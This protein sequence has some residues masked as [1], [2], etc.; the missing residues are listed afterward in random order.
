MR[1]VIVSGVS[2]GIGYAVAKKLI[3]QGFFVVGV[4]RSKHEICE[5]L[6]N[7]HKNSMSEYICDIS[8]ISRI[9]ELISEIVKVEDLSIVRDLTRWLP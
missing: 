8:E 5:K 1:K 9:P 2:G 3:S 7:E 4:D 6:F